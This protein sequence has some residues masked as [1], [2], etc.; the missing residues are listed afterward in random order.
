[1]A[2]LHALLA[3]LTM[4]ICIGV[5]ACPSATFTSLASSLELGWRD[6]NTVVF[7]GETGIARPRPLIIEHRTSDAQPETF[8]TASS[9]WVPGEIFWQIRVKVGLVQVAFAVTSN[10]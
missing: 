4:L 3:S 5:I 9:G 2:I 1:M 8:P 7:V 10:R 6:Q